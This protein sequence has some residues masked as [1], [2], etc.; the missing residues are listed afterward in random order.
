MRKGAG[1]Y[2][3]NVLLSGRVRTTENIPFLHRWPHEGICP[4]EKAS[5]R[6]VLTAR[7]TILT[8]VSAGLLD[9]NLRRFAFSLY[10]FRCV[11]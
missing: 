11:R 9:V 7:A 8:A 1:S 3:G 5:I 6:Q 4:K 10:N 2:G